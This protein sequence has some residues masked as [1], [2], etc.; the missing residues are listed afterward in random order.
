[1]KFILN[2]GLDVKATRTLAVDVVLQMIAANE[3]VTGKHV[4]VQSDTEATVVVEATYWG[5]SVRQALA[6]M[7]N[8]SVDL[9]QDCIGVYRP[10]TGLG[11]LIGPKASAWG[12]FNP[13]YFFMLNGQRLGQKVAA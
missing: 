7:I 6:N 9:Q 1:M 3:F 13:D 5:S 12:K 8:I 11:A 10:L 2:I 4:V